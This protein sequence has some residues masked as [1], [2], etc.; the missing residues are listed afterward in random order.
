M[1]ISYFPSVHCW[2]PMLENF[3]TV[4]LSCPKHTVRKFLFRLFLVE[5][6][7]LGQLIN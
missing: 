6:S 7:Y 4:K 5:I 1:N 3:G 2:L